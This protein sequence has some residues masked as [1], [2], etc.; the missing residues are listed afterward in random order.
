[1]PC[2]IFCRL[3]LLPLSI[4]NQ[5]GSVGSLSTVGCIATTAAVVVVV[6]CGNDEVG[7]ADGEESGSWWGIGC[8]IFCVLNYVCCCVLFGRG[9]DAMVQPTRK[10]KGN[11]QLVC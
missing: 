7:A 11:R 2:V 8:C 3:L 6:A 4:S 9:G 5:S 10:K 1:M